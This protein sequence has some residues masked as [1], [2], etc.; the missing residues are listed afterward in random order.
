[1]FLTTP[2]EISRI[3]MNDLEEVVSKK[4]PQIDLMK[5]ILFSAGPW[6]A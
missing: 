4:F 2:E 3:L 1:M 6:G 5:E